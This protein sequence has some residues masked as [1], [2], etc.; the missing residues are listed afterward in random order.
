MNAAGKRKTPL[1]R[2]QDVAGSVDF[3]AGKAIDQGATRPRTN[4]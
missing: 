4:P 3:R 1:L 2:Q